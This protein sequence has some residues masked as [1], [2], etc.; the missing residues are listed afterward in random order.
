MQRGLDYFQP[1]SCDTDP[2]Q[3][4]QISHNTSLLAELSVRQHDVTSA[5]SSSSSRHWCLKEFFFRTLTKKCSRHTTVERNRVQ[6]PWLCCEYTKLQKL[7]HSSSPLLISGR[8]LPIGRTARWV[9]KEG[10]RGCRVEISAENTRRSPPPTLHTSYFYREKKTKTW[11]PHRKWT[12][13]KIHR[14]SK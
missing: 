8:W 9:C 14:N 2:G 10:E 4:E 5:S 7:L 1:I 3:A 11:G 6:Q 12:D 13:W